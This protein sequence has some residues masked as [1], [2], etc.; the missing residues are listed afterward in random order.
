MLEREFN[1]TG[2]LSEPAR[3]WE[4]K[5]ETNRNCLFDYRCV[6]TNSGELVMFQE[7]ESGGL[8]GVANEL[9]VF[10]GSI[11]PK[12]KRTYSVETVSLIDL[13]EQ[14]GAPNVIDYLSIDTEG[15]E[16]EILKSF[17]FSKYVFNFITCE[18]NYGIQRELIN[19]LLSAVG[20]ERVL[21]DLSMY[22]DWFVPKESVD[23]THKLLG[24]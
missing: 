16:Y 20:Y 3:T 10:T 1:W 18:H 23:R 14:H 9:A 12:R 22:E 7:M 5:L 6:W 21:A 19:E 15:S 11:K 17:D 24:I 4:K 2:I 8:S 13:L